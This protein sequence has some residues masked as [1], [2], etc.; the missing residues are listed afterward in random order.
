VAKMSAK[1]VAVGAG[2]EEMVAM[3]NPQYIAAQTVQLRQLPST[4]S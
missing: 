2:M 3:G 4:S 1:E